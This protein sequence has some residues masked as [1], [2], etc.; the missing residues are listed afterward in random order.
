MMDP[1]PCFDAVGTSEPTHHHE[2]LTIQD[3]GEKIVE[4]ARDYLKHFSVKA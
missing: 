4:V 1:P 3:L 2:D